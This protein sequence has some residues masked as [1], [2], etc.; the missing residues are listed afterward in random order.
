MP[1]R[2]PLFTLVTAV[3][4]VVSGLVGGGAAVAAPAVT[5]GP[6]GYLPPAID[7]GT[8]AKG[9]PKTFECGRVVVPLDWDDVGGTTISLAVTRLKHT[10]K[11]Y[12]GV[13]LV[14]PGGPG[15]SGT[16]YPV[17]RDAVPD[18]AGDSYDWIG[19]D[20]RGVGESRPALRCI[21]DYFTGPRPAYVPSTKAI[22][23]AWLARSKSYAAACAR[24]NG[25]LLAH[26]TT[27]DSVKDMDAIRAA[28]GEEQI[29]FFGYSYGTSLG[30]TYGTLFPTH[31]RRAVLDSNVDPR[32]DWYQA[33]FDQDVAFEKTFRVFAGWV[34]KHDAAYHL[35]STQTVVVTSLDTARDRLNAHPVGTIGGDEF[36]DTLLSAGYYQS[37]WPD[38]ARFASDWIVRHDRKALKQ[39][40]DDNGAEADDNGYAVYLATSCN[41]SRWPGY[42]IYRADSW[43]YHR[44]APFETWGNSWYN[45]PCVTW[46]LPYQ[47][48]VDID[49]TKVSSMLLI[50]ET[51]DAATPYAGSLETRRRF[52]NSV[53]LAE[54]GGTTHAGSLGGNACV[55]DTIARYLRDATLPR[56]KPGNGADT[57]CAPSSQPK[58]KAAASARSATVAGRI[59]HELWHAGPTP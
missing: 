49:G 42:R 59:A 44:V 16:S 29:N 46:P 43:R 20:P 12:Q 40:Y 53:L 2:R 17:L 19:F 41:E 56:R 57:I 8:C 1:L 21:R 11:R 33:N 30:Q 52:P 3:A 38:I 54:P 58:P 34:A 31:L 22:E 39:G 18:N 27:E 7:W 50:D 25:A 32:S 24:R 36:S 45:A 47:A 23:R 37:T 26:I 4:V 48:P 14:N 13:M 51:L 10:T 55:D 15:G 6:G 5:P 28:L 35:G 9:L